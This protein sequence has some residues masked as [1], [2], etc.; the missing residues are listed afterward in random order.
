MISGVS[1]AVLCFQPACINQPGRQALPAEPVSPVNPIKY[2]PVR[3]T[4][5]EKIRVF[6]AKTA[7]CFLPAAGLTPPT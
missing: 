3:E 1:D 2:R 7:D 4:C 5:Q 6:F